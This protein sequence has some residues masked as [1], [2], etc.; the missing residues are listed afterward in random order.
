MAGWW[1]R[2][3]ATLV[4]GLIILALTLVASAPLL[5]G[6]WDACRVWYADAHRAVLMG[7]QPTPFTDERYK[8]LSALADVVPE[9]WGESADLADSNNTTMAGAPSFLPASL[10]H[11]ESNSPVAFS[12]RCG[13][14]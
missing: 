12:G 10:A 14:A 8:T 7:G 3:G 13:R 2:F 1:S 4:D 6:F 5:P 9:L 11:K